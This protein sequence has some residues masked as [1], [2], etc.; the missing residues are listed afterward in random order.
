MQEG[1]L[2]NLKVPPQQAGPFLDVHSPCYSLPQRPYGFFP[3]AR[4]GSQGASRAA[5]GKSGLHARGEGE[6]VLVI[7]F[8]YLLTAPHSMWDLGFLARD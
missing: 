5:R 6:R 1:H 3:E 8:I 2:L 7:T 4:R